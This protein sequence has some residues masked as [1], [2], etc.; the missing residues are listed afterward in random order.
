VI[1]F[2]SNNILQSNNIKINDAILFNL[3]LASRS[4]ALNVV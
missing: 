3:I 2:K 4:T 1:T